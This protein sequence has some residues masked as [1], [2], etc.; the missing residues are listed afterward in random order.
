MNL[1]RRL[2]GHLQGYE[3]RTVSN[4]YADE[5]DVHNNSAITNC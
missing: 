4:T 3:R 5:V 1:P 2:A